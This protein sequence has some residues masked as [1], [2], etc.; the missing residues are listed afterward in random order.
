VK[1]NEWIDVGDLKER[2]EE[3]EE[4]YVTFRLFYNPM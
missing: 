4:T 3:G 2:K 1:A